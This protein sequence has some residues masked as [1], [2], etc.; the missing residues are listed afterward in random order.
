MLSRL[1]DLFPGLKDSGYQVTSLPATAY[2]CVA[3][4]AGDTSAWWWPDSDPD[5]DAAFWPAGLPRAETVSAFIAAFATLG[6]RPCDNSD[7]EPSFEKVALFAR[8]D[9]VSAHAARQLPDGAWT[10]KL[11]A[12]EDVSHPLGALDGDAY[13]TVVQVLK[14]PRAVVGPGAG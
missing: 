13:G 9:S 4:A 12:L 6:Y 7:R 2:N 14:R 5:N 1:E 8:P 11:G 3:W 10:S